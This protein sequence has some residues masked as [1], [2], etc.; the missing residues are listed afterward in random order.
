MWYHKLLVTHVSQP[1]AVVAGESVTES[2]VC[3]ALPH[4]TWEGA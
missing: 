4:L 1:G 2:W 3:F